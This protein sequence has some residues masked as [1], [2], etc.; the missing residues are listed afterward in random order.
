MRVRA[1]SRISRGRHTRRYREH[2]LDR[3]KII[4]SFQVM[5]AGLRSK[6]RTHSTQEATSQQN[7]IIHPRI[8]STPDNCWSSK[9]LLSNLR[10]PLHVSP[11]TFHL[12]SLFQPWTVGLPAISLQSITIPVK[13]RIL[14][15]RVCPQKV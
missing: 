11:Y 1:K 8:G 10:P 3:T 7:A 15:V 12:S 14:T 13:S 2:T 6:R 5:C 4:V 9:P